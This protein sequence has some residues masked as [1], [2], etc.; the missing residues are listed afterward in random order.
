MKKHHENIIY[1]TGKDEL[2]LVEC[3]FCLLSDR[4]DG[5]QKTLKF[6]DRQN[7]ITR[8]WVVTGS[9]EFGLPCSADEEIYIAMLALS[10]RNGFKD[11]TVYFSQ[12]ELLKLMQ[13]PTSGHQ[14]K[15][16]E[17][18]LSR[19]SGV[20]IFADYFWNRGEFKAGRFM[21]HILDSAFL[22]KSKKNSHNS[23]FEW[24]K[25]VFESLANGNVKNLNLE[26][27]FSL[28][29]AIS[30]RFFRLWDKWLYKNDQIS[31]DLKELCFEKLGISRNLKY[32]SLLKQALSPALKEHKAKRLLSS[33]TYFKKRNGSWMLNIK[34]HTENPESLPKPPPPPA[35][36]APKDDPLFEKLLLLK[37]TAKRATIL[38]QTYSRE[39]IEGWLMAI[40]AME[41][42]PKS[43]AGCLITALK[44]GWELPEE[45]RRKFD[46][47]RQETEKKLKA[48]YDKF[49][50]DMVDKYLKTLPDEQIQREIEDH[51]EVFY[52]KYPHYE[53]FRGGEGIR[54]HIRHDYKI[55]K[56]KI[57]N[58]PTF[59]QWQSK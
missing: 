25:T 6:I 31:F 17:L 1:L 41:P 49:I 19:L 12:Y 30:R 50:L 46:A 28:S 40:N 53:E 56:S 4:A 24:S 16:L 9:D 33:A 59:E 10:K 21:F 54:P 55:E 52:A 26:T 37:I 48:E 45:I 14:Y 7:G 47:E 51:A 27:Y 8:H 2:N 29:T 35:A 39:L 36:E 20:T 3:P 22:D 18:A 13:W 57:L 11:R 34:R 32:P 38:L 42:A 43:K 5:E 23:Y 44:E 15:R 58:L